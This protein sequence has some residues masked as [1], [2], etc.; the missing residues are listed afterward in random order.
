MLKLKLLAIHAI[1]YATAN[2]AYL[3]SKFIQ[4][5]DIRKQSIWRR[6]RR[7]MKC[8]TH[9][10]PDSESA[11]PQKSSIWLITQELVFYAVLPIFPP[12]NYC[13][14]MT[15]TDTSNRIVFMFLVTRPVSIFDLPAELMREAADLAC[16]IPSSNEIAEEVTNDV[17]GIDFE[18]S[19][20][21][22]W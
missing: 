8:G 12:S 7:E 5:L 21:I 4:C 13:F 1:M 10:F 3:V 6:F 16:V 17:N 19:E 9:L 15:A 22:V 2:P 18:W 14:C 11:L 20:L